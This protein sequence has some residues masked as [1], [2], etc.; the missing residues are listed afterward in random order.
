MER[1]DRAACRAGKRGA[2]GLAAGG[3]G[4]DHAAV[5]LHD[6]Q[7]PSIQPGFDTLQVA[8]DE[9]RD[10]GVDNGRA[11]ALILAVFRQDLAGE[12]YRRMAAQRL[13]QKLLVLRVQE[14]EEQ[15]YR[16]GLDALRADALGDRGG[17]GRGQRLKHG[18][19]RRDPLVHLEAPRRRDERLGLLRNEGV[20]V[21]AVLPPNGEHIRKAAR[22][23]ERRACASPLQQRI[24]GN[25]RAVDNV[26]MRAEV[27]VLHARQ[28]RTRR[29][30]GRGRALV[31]S[32]T[33][34]LDEDEVRKRAANID[35][36]NGCGSGVGVHHGRQLSRG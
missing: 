7:P 15:A 24:C 2:G 25:G 1:A 19:I 6:A 17:T 34:I 21:G 23:D 31:H 30:V 3:C 10:I 27:K 22:G 36:E 14:G 18:S 20:E 9:R 11:R 8:I 26:G 32:D 12:R 16:D 13:G 28:Q 29:I 35:A 5:G 4:V 33:P